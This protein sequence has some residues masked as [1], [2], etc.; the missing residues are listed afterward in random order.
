HFTVRPGAYVALSIRDTGT[1]MTD[2]T[3]A[4]MFEPF[5]TTKE[6]GK[7]TGLGLSMVFGIVQQCGG[8]ITVDSVLGEG[9]TFGIHLPRVD[10]AVIAE[11]SGPAI[12]SPRG[13]ETILLVEDVEPLR[14]IVRRVL[15]EHGYAVLD[16][17]DAPAALLRAE[18]FRGP[19]HLL[20]TDVVLPGLS[21]RDLAG[22]LKASR[23]DMK[24]LFT[25]GYTDD[26]MMR[27]GVADRGVAFMQKPFTPE[28]LARRV[29]QVLDRSGPAA[30]P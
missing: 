27:R 24:V 23:P 28:T 16:A 26:A 11:A 12:T 15:V 21:G 29:R 6:A 25:S 19:I 5:F 20:L 3:K 13:T 4:R 1:G 18:K 9:T 22:R 17:V 30:L 2:E 10:S 8:Y 7:G 14:E